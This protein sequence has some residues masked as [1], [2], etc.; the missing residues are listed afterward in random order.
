[1][2]RQTPARGTKNLCNYVANAAAESRVLTVDSD[3]AVGD[4]VYVVQHDEW[5]EMAH[6]R[7]SEA[8]WNAL[9]SIY[10]ALRTYEPVTESQK[11]FYTE[12]VARVNDVTGARRERLNDNEEEQR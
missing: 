5:P 9:A 10:A 7:E 3:Q 1:M 4:Y 2:D 8:A 11:V 6:G 12:T